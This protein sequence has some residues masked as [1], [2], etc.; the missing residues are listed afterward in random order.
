MSRDKEDTNASCQWLQLSWSL[1]GLIQGGLG[2]S[3]V[4][5]GH[6]ASQPGL[7]LPCPG[8]CGP[9]LTT[10]SARILYSCRI[11]CTSFSEHWVSVTVE[12]KEMPPP[13]LGWKKGKGEMPM[14]G[15]LQSPWVPQPLADKV[16]NL[17]TPQPKDDGASP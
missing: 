14:K 8:G 9:S 11:S 5:L 6:R 3:A 7:S 1:L 13:F 15:Q 17:P 10:L 2:W 16:P 12:L 4:T